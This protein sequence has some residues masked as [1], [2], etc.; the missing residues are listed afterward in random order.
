MS[1]CDLSVVIIS[2]NVRELLRRCLDSIQEG[3]K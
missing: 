3:L 1:R 2:W